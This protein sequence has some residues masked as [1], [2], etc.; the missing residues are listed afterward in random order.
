[1][2]T[3]LHVCIT[4]FIFEIVL[5]TTGYENN[6]LFVYT[7]LFFPNYYKQLL[8]NIMVGSK[9]KNYEN[10]YDKTIILWRTNEKFRSIGLL[11]N[12]VCISHF[13]SPI[14]QSLVHL[15][16]SDGMKLFF[17]EQNFEVS[18]LNYEVGL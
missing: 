18:S 5:V 4:I 15:T 1:M 10:V 8:L 14:E 16:V 9:E 3:H 7:K 2:F 17:Q 6:A 12:I 11:Q 13:D